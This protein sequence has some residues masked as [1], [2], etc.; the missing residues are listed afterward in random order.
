MAAQ[1]DSVALIDTLLADFVAAGLPFVGSVHL[2]CTDDDRP[3]RTGEWLVAGA[4]GTLTLRREHAKGDAA[5]RGQ[6][7][8][9]LAVLRGE[10]DLDTIDVV[11]DAAVADRFLTAFP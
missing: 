1:Q 9:L 6:A 7:D 4:D 2:H 3:A 5:L 10:A 11:G 8:A